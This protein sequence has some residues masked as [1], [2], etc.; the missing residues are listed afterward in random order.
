MCNFSEVD[1]LV[2]ARNRTFGTAGKLK[3]VD[4]LFYTSREAETFL[5]I[6]AAAVAAVFLLMGGYIY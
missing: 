2:I 3:L 5:I 1:Q 6:A 4:E